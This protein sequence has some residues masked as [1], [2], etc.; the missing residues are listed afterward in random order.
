[1]EDKKD[2]KPMGKSIKLN[3]K[4]HDKLK[5]LNQSR[6]TL[7]TKKRKTDEGYVNS[8]I[9]TNKIFITSRELRAQ[10]DKNVK[11]WEMVLTKMGKK[12]DVDLLKV[13]Y[14]INY[15]TGTLTPPTEEEQKKIEAMQKANKARQT[16]VPVDTKDIELKPKIVK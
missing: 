12:Y 15:E 10:I 4:E 1:M 2:S 8:Q 9:I 14:H 13:N 11:E 3:T 6:N 16:G 5:F 7:E